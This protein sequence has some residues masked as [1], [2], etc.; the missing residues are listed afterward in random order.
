MAR[1]APDR[2]DIMADEAGSWNDKIIEE[3]HANAGKVGGPF[4][5]QVLVLLT[6]VGAK[7]GEKR[8][9]PLVSTRDGDRIIIAASAGG[10]DKHPAWYRNVVANPEVTV[11]IGTEKFE[12]TA[13]EITDR[14]ERDRL[15]A[16]MVAAMPGFAEYETKTDR[17]IPVIALA[18]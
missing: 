10:A 15:Y 18:R 11:E 1:H 7:T 8:T 16:G 14:A 4:E 17:L 9:T 2:K 12:A 5:D 13:T 3:F 6:M